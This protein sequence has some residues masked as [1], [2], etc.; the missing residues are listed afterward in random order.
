MSESSNDFAVS[1]SPA[2]TAPTAV[3]F[4]ERWARWQ[5]KGARHDARVAPNMRVIVAVLLTV[6][7]I[8]A[9]VVLR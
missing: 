2:E 1:P 7:V 4:D 5:E 3:T 6:G 9:A 8:W